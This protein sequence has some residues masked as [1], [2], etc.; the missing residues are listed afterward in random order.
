VA[1]PDYQSL[2]LPVL[3]LARRISDSAPLFA[4]VILCVGVLGIGG[5][6]TSS[7]ENHDQDV[8]GDTTRERLA[9]IESTPFEAAGDCFRRR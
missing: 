9:S 8:R 4:L 7:A 2:M 3:K 1:I 6:R 5:I